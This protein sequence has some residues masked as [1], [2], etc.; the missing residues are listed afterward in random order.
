M[1]IGQQGLADGAQIDGSATSYS[2]TVQATDGTLTTQ[3]SYTINVTFPA[4]LPTLTTTQIAAM[5]TAEVAVLTTAQ[6]AS[7]TPAQLTV[8][9]APQMAALSTT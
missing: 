2:I 7:L 4:D 5:A 3:A 9:T 1:D 6:M 8:L